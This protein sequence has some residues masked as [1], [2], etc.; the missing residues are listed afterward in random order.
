MGYREIEIKR[1]KGVVLTVSLPLPGGLPFA[2]FS[3]FS[4]AA[5]GVVV[6]VVITVVFVIVVIIFVGVVVVIV[7]VAFRSPLE[8]LVVDSA[9]AT[10]LLRFFF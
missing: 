8:G 6:V 4:S 2:F 1:K 10:V 9:L 3:S 7:V 5:K